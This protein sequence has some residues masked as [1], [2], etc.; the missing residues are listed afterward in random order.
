ML[1]ARY[2][3]RYH[4]PPM[5][6]A[7]KKAKKAAAPAAGEITDQKQIYD[8]LEKIL[9]RYSPPLAG[10]DQGVKNKRNYTLVSKKPWELDGRKYSE[11][12]FSCVVEQKGYV[13]FYFMPT[14]THTEIKKVFSPA[15]LKLL[16]GKSCFHV[17]KLDKDLQAD[18]VK[19]LQAGFDL[20]KQKGMI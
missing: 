10:S 16:K 14:Y 8:T 1:S 17:K 2:G 20:Y 7:L 13:G 19:A 15:L 12:W 18:I 4:L 9:K 11:A 6:T 5:A 3:G